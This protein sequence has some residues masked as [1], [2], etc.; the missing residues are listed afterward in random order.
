MNQY[1]QA[2]KS[3]HRSIDGPKKQAIALRKSQVHSNKLD[4]LWPYGIENGQQQV[5]EL[6]ITFLTN[7]VVNAL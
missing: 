2:I 6:A 3:V 5:L 1:S 7:T 4:S